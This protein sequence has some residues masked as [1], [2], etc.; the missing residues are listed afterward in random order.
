MKPKYIDL[1]IQFKRQLEEIK[2]I[3]ESKENQLN[4]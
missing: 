3:Y 2:K 1:D 4:D